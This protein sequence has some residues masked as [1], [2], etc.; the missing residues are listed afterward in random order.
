[1]CSAKGAIVARRRVAMAM[2]VL[3]G[4]EKEIV[5]PVRVLAEG[6]VVHVP[7]AIVKPVPARA[8]DV[9]ARRWLAVRVAQAAVDRVPVVLVQ[10]VPA[11]KGVDLGRKVAI[12]TRK[13]PNSIGSSIK[14]C[15]NSR[16]S[17]VV[18][19]RHA[20]RDRPWADRVVPALAA[21]S[22]P[23]LDLQVSAGLDSADRA[24]PCATCADLGAIDPPR[25]AKVTHHGAKKARATAS[26]AKPAHEMG[27]DVARRKA[28]VVNR[29][30]KSAAGKVVRKDDP[31]VAVKGAPREGQKDVLRVAPKGDQKVVLKVDL[32]DA[33]RAQVA[34]ADSVGSAAAFLDSLALVQADPVPV[35][36]DQGAVAIALIHPAMAKGVVRAAASAPM[37]RATANGMRTRPSS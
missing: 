29:L 23:D 8:E 1:L 13:S 19:V 24:R 25:V 12:S 10:G 9:V 2:L 28:N 11:R 35:V 5:D 15:G 21:D 4:A 3:K 36:P 32:P 6:G 27:N 14:S 26:A 30:P 17:S 37:L 16:H 20:V 7:M 33:D 18:A 31:K 34:H 22:V